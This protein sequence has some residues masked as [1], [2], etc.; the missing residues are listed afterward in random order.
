MTFAFAVFTGGFL[1][2]Q[3]RGTRVG[4]IIARSLLRNPT[5]LTRYEPISAINHE[6]ARLIRQAFDITVK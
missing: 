2:R 6:G 1:S 5:L 4:L 3:R